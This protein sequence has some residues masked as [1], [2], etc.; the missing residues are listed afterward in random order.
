[1][2]K[3]VLPAVVAAAVGFA[4]LPSAAWADGVPCLGTGS[5]YVP[6][7]TYVAPGYT[8]VPPTYYVAPSSYSFSYSVPFYGSYPRYSYGPRYYHHNHYRH[9]HARHG[10]HHR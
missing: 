9:G 1:V 5:Y 4:F 3:F 2:R 7:T 6:P 10:H 8:Y